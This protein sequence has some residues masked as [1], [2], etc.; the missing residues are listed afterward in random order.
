MLLEWDYV[1]VF[2]QL[3]LDLSPEYKDDELTWTNW[4][5]TPNAYNFRE[6]SADF[7][8]FLSAQLTYF[9]TFF[10]AR[11]SWENSK[12]LSHFSRRWWPATAKIYLWEAVFRVGPWPACWEK[13]PSSAVGKKNQQ[14]PGRVWSSPGRVWSP[15]EFGLMDLLFFQKLMSEE[16]NLPFFRIFGKVV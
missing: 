14:S 2:F 7:D 8:M 6:I 10:L 4:F 12:A 15:D 5:P 9:V 1:V 11:H 13:M 16:K 3:A